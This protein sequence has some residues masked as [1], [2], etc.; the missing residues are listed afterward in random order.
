M[1]EALTSVSSIGKQD[2]DWVYF[3]NPN[4]L[5]EGKPVKDALIT[6]VNGCGLRQGDRIL[7]Y[8]PGTIT[9]SALWG[10]A[11]ALCQFNP[12]TQPTTNPCRIVDNSL[13]T[14]L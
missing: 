8:Y 7:L 9:P 6:G 10:Q 3:A 1:T 4:Y 5:F 2:S 14:H 11:C 13:A 12:N